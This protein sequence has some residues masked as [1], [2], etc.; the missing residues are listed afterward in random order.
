MDN[1][2]KVSFDIYFH[3]PTQIKCQII[4]KYQSQNLVTFQFEYM[5]T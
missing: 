2:V 4:N 3:E 5:E 1:K